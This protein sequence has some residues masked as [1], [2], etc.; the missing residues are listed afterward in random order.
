MEHLIYKIT[1]QLNDRFYIGMHSTE[2][3]DDGYLGS[4]KRIKAEVKKYGKENFRKEILERVSSRKLLQEREAQIVNA[5]LLQDPLCLNLKNGGEGGGKIWSKE[6]ALVLHTAGHKA[7]TASLTSEQRSARSV[8]TNATR[9]IRGNQTNPIA[10]TEAARLSAKRK[11]TMQERGHM[12]GEK[13]SQFGTCWVTN[14]SEVVKIKKDFLEEYLAKG[15][16]R[17]RSKRP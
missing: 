17:G 5:A 9:K 11:V 7:M 8:K 16:S 10:A 4:G 12:Q 3:P 6:H 1:N 2:N 15:Y 13:N 14:G